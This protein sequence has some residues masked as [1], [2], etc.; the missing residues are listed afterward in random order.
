MY[1]ITVLNF[2]NMP[3]YIH[4]PYTYIVSK[5]NIYLYDKKKS[6]SLASLFKLFLA[7]TSKFN[8]F[9]IM[10]VYSVNGGVQHILCCIFFVCFLFL[11]LFVFLLCALCWHF[12]WIVHFWLPLRY[13]LAFIYTTITSVKFTHQ[14]ANLRFELI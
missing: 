9:S 1:F 3:L 13:S 14:N 5:Y 2:V 10:Y 7:S 12:L 8:I 11:F 4:R 6:E